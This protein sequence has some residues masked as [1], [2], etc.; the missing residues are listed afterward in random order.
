MGLDDA[1]QGMP[2]LS[3]LGNAGEGLSWPRGAV[4][5]WAPMGSCRTKP[6]APGSLAAC[7]SG[8]L[9]RAVPLSPRAC[10]T[11]VRV[12]GCPLADRLLFTLA[13]QPK[14]ESDAPSDGPS[15]LAASH[16]TQGKGPAG[17]RHSSVKDSVLIQLV[18]TPAASFTWE[19]EQLCERSNQN[20][21]L[22]GK[23]KVWVRQARE[24]PSCKGQSPC[25][26][27]SCASGSCP[28]PWLGSCSGNLACHLGSPMLLARSAAR[29][30]GGRAGR[31]TR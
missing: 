27:T 6:W 19:G 24:T 13:A 31:G 9:C 16:H 11:R 5:L 28:Q 12:P 25:Q 26:Q 14:A 18:S 2:R 7:V 10:S 3:G 30:A 22:L 20:K 4:S 21:Y 1:T 15:P 23:I 17:F 29:G 8:S